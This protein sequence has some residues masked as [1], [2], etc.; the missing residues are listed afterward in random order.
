MP[1]PRK[2]KKPTEAAEAMPMGSTKAYGW[3][4]WKQ[5]ARR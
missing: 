1:E 4:Q 3:R 5:Q 2:R